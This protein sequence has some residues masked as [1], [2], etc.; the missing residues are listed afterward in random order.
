MRPT[1]LHKPASGSASRKGKGPFKEVTRRH[2]IGVEIA[3]KSAWVRS[4]PAASAPASAAPV[5]AMEISHLHAPPACKRC[6][7]ASSKAFVSLGRIVQHLTR[8]AWPDSPARPRPP[9]GV[10]YRSSLL[11]IGSCT[12]TAGHEVGKPAWAAPARCSAEKT[13]QKSKACRL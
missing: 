2:K 4:R 12:V 1:R 13:R 11:K 8:S 3:R 9:A 6:T 5:S 10:V 7:A